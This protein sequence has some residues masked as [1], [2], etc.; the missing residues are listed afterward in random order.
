MASIKDVAKAANVSLSTVSKVLNGRNDA[1]ISPRTRDIVIA[2]AEQIGYHPSIVARGLTGK[3]ME[4]IGVIM[5]YAE[6]S[7]TSDP[8]LGPCLDGILAVAKEHH[9]KTILFLEDSWRDIRKKLPIYC[10]GNCDG[11]I[12]IIP[13]LDSDIIPALEQH[14]RS[15]PFVVAGDSRDD[16][17]LTCV[18]VD[19]IRT[20]MDV[21]RYLFRLGHT[22]I[23]AFCGYD[24]F[25][26]SQQRLAGFRLAY[27]EAGLPLSDDWIF[28]GGYR[29]EFGA[30]N[31]LRLL[32]YLQNT[33]TDKCPTAVFC[34]SDSIALGALQTFKDYKIAIPEQLSVVGFDDIPAAALPHPALTTV[35]QNV[36]R[37]GEE[38]T[39]LLLG[40]IGGQI[41]IGERILLPG[42]IIPRDTTASLVFEESSPSN[43]P[44]ERV[45]NH[46]P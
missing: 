36:R 40:R 30:Q 11:L 2:A 29:H 14:S 6:S 5:A 45:F 12:L 18:D 17:P 26:S 1:H 31:A 23:A 33:P 44:H 43:F 4:A 34:F 38:A 10:D 19:N 13:R 42:E 24:D 39:R 20:S 37:I 35:R 21:V 22:R 28:P 32:Q 7:V 41:A 3:R 27:K 9:Q 8:Y 15:V 16:M 46:E 25:C